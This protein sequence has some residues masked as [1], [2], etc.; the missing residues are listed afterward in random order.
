MQEKCA[1]ASSPR[2]LPGPA[3]GSRFALLKK[4]GTYISLFV[5]HGL[6]ILK[7]NGKQRKMKEFCKK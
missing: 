5:I 1:C 6:Q 7:I 2:F 4:A 3:K